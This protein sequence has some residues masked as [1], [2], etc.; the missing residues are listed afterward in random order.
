MALHAVTHDVQAESNN[1]TT[2]HHALLP[3]QSQLQMKAADNSNSTQT[4]TGGHPV[5]EKIQ[6]K[7]LE[8]VGTDPNHAPPTPSLQFLPENHSNI[9]KTVIDPHFQL[10]HRGCVYRRRRLF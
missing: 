9:T 3:S 4:L 6:V 8:G 1:S 2:V 5:Q 10:P 7:A